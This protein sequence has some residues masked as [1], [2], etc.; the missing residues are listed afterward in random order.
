M[1]QNSQGL[2]LY[3]RPTACCC[4]EQAFCRKAICLAILLY[5]LQLNK[6]SEKASTVQIGALKDLKKE[7]GVRRNSL[8]KAMIAEV[9]KELYEDLH[10]RPHAEAAART[11]HQFVRHSSVYLLSATTD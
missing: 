1:C 10:A 2:E 11:S 8:V 9:E 4:D 7:L 5:Y 3:A 6:I